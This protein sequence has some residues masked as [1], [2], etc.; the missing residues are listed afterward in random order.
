MKYPLQILPMF[1]Q[2]PD[3]DDPGNVDV[4][5]VALANILLDP[6]V[7]YIKLD[8]AIVPLGDTLEAELFQATT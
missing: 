2:V 6:E 1:F 8:P 7:R 3:K 5:F 4:P